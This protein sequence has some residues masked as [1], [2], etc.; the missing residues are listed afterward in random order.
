MNYSIDEYDTWGGRFVEFFTNKPN[1]TY[2]YYTIQDIIDDKP[3]ELDC[4]I[5]EINLKVIT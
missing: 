3:S 2:V 4:Y 1:H 5:Y